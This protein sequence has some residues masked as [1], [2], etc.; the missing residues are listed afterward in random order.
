MYFAIISSMGLLNGE[1]SL[2]NSFTADSMSLSFRH[3]RM[4]GVNNSTRW[5]TD[6]SLSFISPLSREM[7]LCKTTH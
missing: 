3:L 5:I 2:T 6:A 1:P 7:F 4:D